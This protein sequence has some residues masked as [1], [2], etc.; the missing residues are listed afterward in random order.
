MFRF[1]IWENRPSRRVAR[2]G[3]LVGF[4]CS[5]AGFSAQGATPANAGP[6]DFSSSANVGWIAYT[7]EFIPPPT[8]PGP[9]MDDPAHPYISNVIAGR[10]GQQPT[11]PVG[12]LSN[13]ILQPW[14]REAVGKQNERVLSGK[15]GYTLQARCWPM[16]VPG[17]HL[18]PV[19]PVF[20]VQT[21]TEV[22]M[23]WQGDHMVRH[24]H[25]NVPHSAD[26]KPSWFGE[27]V[28]HYEGDTLVVDTIGLND[29]TFVD[30]YRTPHTEQLHVVQRFQLIEGG[31]T[32]E[33][34]LHVEDPGAFTMPW[35][36]SQR[37]R[38]TEESPMVEETCAEGMLFNYFNQDAEPIPT[39]S[40]PD[41]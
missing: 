33:V 41:F 12:D 34:K 2:F 17:F 6:P 15:S 8:G 23:T 3:F 40:K 13:P 26:V 35:D 21:P 14:A 36:A 30:N 10:T 20:I 37:Y 39:A 38:R 19:R 28:G 7:T 1:S 32:L 24:I 25:L 4:T 5:A 9:V 22:L 16:G 27:S 11:F 18:Y 29:R 31:K